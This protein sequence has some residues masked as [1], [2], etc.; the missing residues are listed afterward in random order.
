V[1]EHSIEEAQNINFNNIMILEKETGY[2]DHLVKEATE[3]HLHPNNFNRDGGF[4]LSRA[5]YPVTNMLKQDGKTP[6]RKQGQT[7]QV[8][9][10]TH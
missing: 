5:W 7:L 4:T 9:D 6:L 2:M 10:S 1:A 3:I 8:L